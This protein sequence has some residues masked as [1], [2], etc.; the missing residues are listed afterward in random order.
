MQGRTVTGVPA[1]LDSAPSASRATTTMLRVPPLLLPG[2]GIGPT[3]PKKAPSAAIVSSPEA[4]P[5]HR[6]TTLSNCDGVLSS[7]TFTLGKTCV[8]PPLQALLLS[9]WLIDPPGSR[10]Q[11]ITGGRLGGG[12]G[13][14]G[15]RVV[16][17]GG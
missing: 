14:V 11:V 12:G 5:L 10:R 17:G 6:T 15:G 3:A 1:S 2:N 16:G 7:V 13:L 4:K 9:V 8:L